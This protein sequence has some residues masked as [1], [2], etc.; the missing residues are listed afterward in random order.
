VVC[1]HCDKHGPL[2]V[3]MILAEYTL[4]PMSSLAELYLCLGPIKKGGRSG[5]E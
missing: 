2:I 5:Q 1:F 3:T 4:L